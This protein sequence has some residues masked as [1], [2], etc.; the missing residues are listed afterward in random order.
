[1]QAD[2][3]VPGQRYEHHLLLIIQEFKSSISKLRI[4][5]IFPLHKNSTLQNYCNSKVLLT[6]EK[7]GGLKVVAIDGSRFKLFTLEFS[8]NLCTV[9]RPH[10]VRGLKLFS[11][12]YLNY[13]NM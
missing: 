11:E 3:P 9:C 7:R 12:G 4:L 6:N 8:K 5:H 10:P 1:V 13:M 2:R